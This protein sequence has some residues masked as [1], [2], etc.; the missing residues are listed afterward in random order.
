MLDTATEPATTP[1]RATALAAA[2]FTAPWGFVVANGAY[3]WATRNGGSDA[4]GAGALALAAGHPG[5]TRLSALAAMVASLLMVPAVLGVQRLVGDRSRRLV[6]SAAA[7]TAAGYICYFAIASS[8]FVTIAMARHG[9]PTADFAAVL[10]EGQS[11]PSML[12]VFLLFVLGNLV[13][14]VLLA[15]ALWRSRTVAPWVAVALGAWA[16]LHIT[17]LIAG[18][19]WFEV[20]G[21]VSQAVA[22]AVVGRTLLSRPAPN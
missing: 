14:T 6:G 9:G 19:E 10:D 2:L 12:W 3:A 11:D 22:L 16:P 13:G 20:A 18:T 21:A 5:L 15:V 7:L 4:D 1:R 8:S 17:G